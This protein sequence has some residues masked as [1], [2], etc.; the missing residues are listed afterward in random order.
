M[1]RS[2]TSLA[3]LFIISL[4][5]AALAVAAEKP[6]GKPTT[7]S[8][9]DDNVTL[10]APAEFAPA[11]PGNNIIAYEFSTPK[12]EGDARDGR[13]TVMTASGGVEANIDRWLTQF[14]QPDGKPSKD[15]AEIKKETIGGQEVHIVDISGTFIDRPA[16]PF[17]GGAA[18]NREGYR[19][20]AAIIVTA[21]HGQH[22]LKFYGPAKTVAANE[23]AF[24]TLV[25]S[26]KVAK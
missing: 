25:R 1:P 7:M 15:R 10:T 23:K 14:T 9:A 16:G 8:L 3:A 20:L 2:L 26:V 19:M 17:S 4:S 22:F 6:E 24:D 13:L 18:V 21:D 5:T 12:V 11:K